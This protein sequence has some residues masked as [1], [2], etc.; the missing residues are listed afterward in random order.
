MNTPQQPEPYNDALDLEVL[1]P[2]LDDAI[3]ADY[4]Q[5]E[6]FL[7]NSGYFTPSSKRISDIYTKTK[8]FKEIADKE[9]GKRTLQVKITANHEL[10]LPTT[11]DLDFYRALQ[12]I[13]DEIIDSRGRIPQPVAVSVK[14]LIRYAGKIYSQQ[15]RIAATEFLKR[16]AL[17]GIIGSIY[18]A[19]RKEYQEMVTGVVRNLYFRGEV[20]KNG[21]V[22]KHTR[23]I[24]SAW[25][26]S[27]Y[28]YRNVRP[29]DYTFYQQ[30]RKPIAKS[31]YTL[32][33]NGWYASRGNPFRKT[34]ASLCDEFLL[35][36]YVHLSDIQRQ[37]D[38][39]HEELKR[40]R[41]L[42]HWEFHQSSNGKNGYVITYYAGKKHFEDLQAQKKRRE[43]AEQITEAEIIKENA[44]LGLI[45]PT[46]KHQLLLADI[47]A[48][49]GDHENQAAY[50]K[51]IKEY[52][53]PLIRMALSETKN[54]RLEKRINK[55]PGA[56]FTDTIKRLAELRA[57]AN[58]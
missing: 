53:E 1:T 44:Q 31:L 29:L 5:A 58:G 45:D 32:L 17:T 57:R 27:N 46:Q 11:S 48:I 42:D 35:R 56:Y 40:L 41:F 20:M 7:E 30:L 33:G 50:L 38:P 8:K 21:D 18:V 52:S 16:L 13:L 12:K 9:G 34:Y 39:A 37:L 55:T 14:R 23:I 36:K 4:V 25:F 47:L 19:K 3:L 54:A 22:A 2:E 24:F 10:G 6:T 49:C 15:N 43:L 51:I 28:Y 26:L